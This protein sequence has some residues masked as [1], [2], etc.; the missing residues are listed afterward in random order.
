MGAAVALHDLDG[1]GLP[2][3]V[4]Y[5]D[6]R[7][8]RVIL[9]PAPGTPD[10]YE[11]FTLDPNPLHYEPATMAPMGSLVG[12]LNEDGLA[13][14]LVYYWGR[15]P[16]AFLR[17]PSRETGPA[18]SAFAPRE[19]SSTSDRWFTN[20]ATLADLDGDGHADLVVANYFPDGSRILD[21]D[22]RGTASMQRSMSR[23]FNSGEKH[24]FIWS[25]ATSGGEPDVRFREEAGVLDDST[26]YGWTLAVGAA[27]LDGDLLP[28]LYF[29]ND[30]GPDRL[31]HNRSHPGSIRFAPVEGRRGLTTPSSKVLGRDSFKGMGVDFG[32][33]NGDGLLDLFVSNIATEFALLESHF[34]FISTGEAGSFR[35]GVAPYVD[36]SEELGLSRSGWGWEARLADF[37]NDGDLEAL[38]AVG[39]MKG[40]VDRWPELQELAMGHDELLSDPGNWPRFASGDDLSGGRRN[41][42]FVRFG[43]RFVD[44]SAEL[45]LAEPGVSRGIATADVD[46]DGRLD[47]AVANQWAASTFHHNESTGSD[48]FLGLHLRLPLRPEAT[49]ARTGHPGPDTPGRPAIGAE[50]SVAL[51]SGRRLV[52]QCDGGNGH[53]GK[54]SPDLHFGLG[55]VTPGTLLSITLRWRDPNGQVRR[56]ELSLPPGWHTVQL[57]WSELKRAIPAGVTS[58]TEMG[59]VDR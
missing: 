47:F 17:R 8:D 52:A 18:R 19:V 58:R 4:V 5:V 7:T 23:A 9:A 34:A 35:E 2:N 3:D 31:L 53:S 39:F 28:E 48:A 16:V 57:G 14:V 29:A 12:D 25:D 54:R 33:L 21:V 45:G 10:R 11:P 36:R 32:D 44:L 26:L 56:E 20:A 37:D 27:D 50:A 41:P 46:G 13:D 24:I 42:F 49:S 43:G 38:Q 51:P 1:D 22:T 55:P 40:D 6:T 59:G 15:T 30:F